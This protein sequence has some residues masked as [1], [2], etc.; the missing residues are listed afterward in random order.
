LSFSCPT[1]SFQLSDA[2]TF[3]ITADLQ[4]GGTIDLILP[5]PK[6]A[7]HPTSPTPPSSEYIPVKSESTP[8][9]T[10]SSQTT[11]APIGISA[12][13]VS[14]SG[15]GS[16][17]SSTAAA[18]PYN[19]EYHILRLRG[20]PYSATMQDVANFFHVRPSPL[21]YSSAL[22]TVAFVPPPKPYELAPDGV[23][24]VLNSD[25]RSAGIA[26]VQF[27]DQRAASGALSACNGKMMGN[28]Y[29]ELFESTK[30]YNGIFSYNLLVILT[31]HF[32]Y[33]D[34]ESALSSQTSY[35][36]PKSGSSGSGAVV[37]LRGLP[38]SATEDDVRDFFAG[39]QIVSIHLTLD[40]MGRPS[41]ESFIEFSDESQASMA[42][43]RDRGMMK[44]RYVQN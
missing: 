40:H 3:R 41:G 13:V 27:V 38:W 35:K 17:G 10:N 5:S 12:A 24:L 1:D 9:P 31:R 33:R 2:N 36:D 26:F 28:R 29:I 20:L 8:A 11:T 21:K 23:H 22:L 34:M 4:E 25:G 39:L 18:L 15:S 37:R 14:G 19:K 43:L 42:R 44:S 16:G 6:P 30:K 7:S 32:A